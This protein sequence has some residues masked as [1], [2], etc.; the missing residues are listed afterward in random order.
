MTRRRNRQRILSEINVVPYIDVMLVLLI[1]F[2]ITAPLLMQGV[3]VKLPT[4]KTKAVPLQHRI[5]IIVSVNKQGQFFVNVSPTPTVPVS[6]QQLFNLTAAEFILAKQAQH[7]R[8][9]F[10]KGDKDVNYGRVV[11][12]M[13]LLQKAGAKSVGLLT[14]SESSGQPTQNQTTGAA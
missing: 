9:V 12:A 14:Q 6:A 1:I 11:L 4:S 8:P 5:P 7:P 13:A 2:M 3:N 10:V